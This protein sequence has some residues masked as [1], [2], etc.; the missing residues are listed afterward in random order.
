M[1]TSDSKRTLSTMNV[2]CGRAGV[3]LTVKDCFDGTHLVSHYWESMLCGSR[4]HRLM[5]VVH[6]KVTNNRGNSL[7]HARRH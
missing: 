5:Q 7:M 2:G 3:Q 1:G 6:A 4:C